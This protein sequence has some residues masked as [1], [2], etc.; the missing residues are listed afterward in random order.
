MLRF[1]DILLLL[2][3]KSSSTTGFRIFKDY[4]FILLKV[5][6]A[7]NILLEGYPTGVANRI[8][9]LV[10]ALML[11]LGISS[12]FLVVWNYFY[13]VEE[14]ITS[15]ISFILVSQVICKIFELITHSKSHR[16]MIKIVEEQTQALQDDRDYMK[17]GVSNFNRVRFHVAISSVAYL[18]AL[19]SLYLS[20]LYALIFKHEFVLRANVQ[21]P[22]TKY[23]E[24]TGWMINYIFCIFLA[25]FSAFTILGN[26]S[27]LK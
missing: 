10:M 24:P 22:F 9:L 3:R 16:E 15:T 25:G 20:P 19:A 1:S 14:V 27:F 18:S 2:F 4:F 26:Q 12:S 23:K 11:L 8:R 7:E 17:I 6:G 5:C 13:E 21:L